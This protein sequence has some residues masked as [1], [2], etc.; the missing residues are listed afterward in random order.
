M[1]PPKVSFSFP[2][3]KSPEGM[4]TISRRLPHNPRR[5]TQNFHR[6]SDMRK[7]GLILSATMLATLPF[8][9]K[10]GQGKALIIGYTTMVLA[11]L[12]VFFGIRTYRDN[13]SSGT[14]T[15]ARAF[16]VGILITV[17]ANFF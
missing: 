12:L 6:G 5:D 2:A 11:G 4:T 15:F 16:A 10:V 13:F 8:L 1:P 14:L 3:A 7:T 9:H 17:I